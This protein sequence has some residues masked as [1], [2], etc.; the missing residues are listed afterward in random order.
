MTSV[1][2]RRGWLPCAV[3]LLL[4]AVATVFFMP[5]TKDRDIYHHD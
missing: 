5:E 3:S 4:I 1:F 2:F